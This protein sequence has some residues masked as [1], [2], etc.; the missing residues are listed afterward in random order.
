MRICFVFAAIVVAGCQK[1]SPS[2]PAPDAAP[3]SPDAAAVDANTCPGTLTSC[4]GNC[5]NE[6][7]DH[8]HCGACDHACVPAASCVSSTCNCPAPFIGAT[9]Q[10]LATQMIQSQPGFVTGVSGV[11]GTDANNHG[12]VVTA[13]ATAPLNTALPVNGQVYV[14]IAYELFTATQAK[15]TFLATGGTVRLTRRC[16][17]GLGGTLQNLTFVEVNPTTLQPIPDGCT[18][19]IAQLAFDIAQPCQ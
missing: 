5:V 4:A 14:A 17:A 19:T 13:S 10:V 11:V 1:D 3:Q 12:V 16:A 18:T 9:P 2:H 6:T 15:S 8:D 7:D